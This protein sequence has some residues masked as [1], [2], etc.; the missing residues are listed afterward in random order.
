MDTTK[1][2]VTDGH[3]EKTN[4]APSPETSSISRDDIE[5]IRDEANTLYNKTLAA[6]SGIALSEA[7]RRRLRGSGVR[8]YGFIDK[9]RDLAV[10]NPQFLPPYLDMDNFYT[11]IRQIEGLRDVAA[12]LEQ[13]LRIVNDNLLLAGDDAF[14][15]A[16]MY[17]NAVREA[18]RRRVPGAQELFR[19]L[20]LF[21]RR[22]RRTDEEPKIP[23]VER[24]VKALLHGKKDGKIVVENEKPHLEGGKHVVEDDTH[25]NNAAWKETEHGEIEEQDR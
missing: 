17:Y 16:L 14:R 5:E 9:T 15:Q 7:E 3:V 21:F 2:E 23:D 4:I 13:T 25:K 24:D 11:S 12:T 8:R 10:D 19:V 6:S 20:E 22:G 1:K 18:A